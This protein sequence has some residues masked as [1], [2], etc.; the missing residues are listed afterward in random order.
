MIIMKIVIYFEK[1]NNS[2]GKKGKDKF[3]Q[4][5]NKNF[6]TTRVCISKEYEKR[7]L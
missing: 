6:S 1:K 7:K 4:K 2:S 3:F 5:M